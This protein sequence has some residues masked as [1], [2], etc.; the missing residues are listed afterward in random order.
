MS[1]EAERES[2]T[3]TGRVKGSSDPK[4]VSDQEEEQG[5]EGP[6]TVR[7]EIFKVDLKLDWERK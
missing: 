1:K 5:E 3:T 6:K 4:S 7:R 2:L